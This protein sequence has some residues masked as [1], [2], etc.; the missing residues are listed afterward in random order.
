MRSTSCDSLARDVLERC[1][2][3]V[4]PAELPRALFEEP[5]VQALFG[6]LVEGLADR[7]E[8]ALCDA[9]AHLFSQAVAHAVEGVDA[10]SLAGHYERVRRVRPVAGTPRRVFVL[11][12]VT[13]G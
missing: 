10:G 12:R 8:P 3:G 2:A 4:P 6:V 11:S 1:L 5:C 7:F 9:Y 13:L